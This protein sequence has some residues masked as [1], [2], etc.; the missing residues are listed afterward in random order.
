[1]EH[2]A[3]CCAM[4]MARVPVMAAERELIRAFKVPTPGTRG[5][6]N[7]VFLKPRFVK[8]GRTS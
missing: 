1:M 4:I 6:W 7:W 8:I 2:M 5:C 3:I